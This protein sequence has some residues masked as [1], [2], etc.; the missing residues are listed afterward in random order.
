MGDLI[1]AT[2]EEK[3]SSNMSKKMR[4][5]KIAAI[6]FMVLFVLLIH[7][8]RTGKNMEVQTG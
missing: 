1:L 6:V 4:V 7:N 2:Y 5:N 3:Y 8:Q